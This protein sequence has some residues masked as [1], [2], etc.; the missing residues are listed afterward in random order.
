[1][2]G[3]DAR[4]YTN[5][6]ESIQSGENLTDLLAKPLTDFRTAYRA[7]LGTIKTTNLRVH[8]CTIYTAVPFTDPVWR[9]Y[10]PLAIGQFNNVI[11][12]EANTYTVPVLR[13]KKI[14]VEESDFAEISPIEPSSQGGGQK[15]VD[16]ILSK[17]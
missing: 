4:Q 14:C 3:N 2:G 9:Q 10:A 17:L 5:L 12:E 16:Y 11:I 15:I 8:V 6:F 1:M 7:M 13:L